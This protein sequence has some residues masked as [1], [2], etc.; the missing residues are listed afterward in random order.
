[1]GRASAGHHRPSFSQPKWLR[2]SA[3]IDYPTFRWLQRFF[4]ARFQGPE[5]IAVDGVFLFRKNVA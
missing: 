5:I 1:M 3:K 2:A 4:L